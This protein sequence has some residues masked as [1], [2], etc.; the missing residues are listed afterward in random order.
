VLLQVS[1]VTTDNAG[2]RS[3]K[4][5]T[6]V[7]VP[8]FQPTIAHN[9]HLI[10]TT[11][12]AWTPATHPHTATV[13]CVTIHTIVPWTP[14]THSHTATVHCVTIHTT[15]VPWT[16]G[17]HPHTATVHCVTI[18]TT[19]VPWTP[20]THPHTMLKFALYNSF[21]IHTHRWRALMIFKF[22]YLR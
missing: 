11:I 5:R 18:H 9:C 8:Q 12:V 2:T 16:P 1:S 14:A 17:T 19:I 6:H 13:H 10:H 21:T 22:F 4:D 20:A 7:T 15:I 3:T